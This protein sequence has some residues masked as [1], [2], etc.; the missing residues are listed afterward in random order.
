MAKFCG[1]CGA[2]VKSDFCTSCGAKVDG[3]QSGNV[4]S[5][6]ANEYFREKMKSKRNH[7]V[8]RITVGIIMIV[9]GFLV[10]VAGCAAEDTDLLISDITGINL[11]L[12]FIY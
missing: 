10:F 5:N 7:N 11:T 3:T 4:A 9:L 2:E 6:E 12:A 8:Y 1:K